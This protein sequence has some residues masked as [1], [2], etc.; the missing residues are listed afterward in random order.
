MRVELGEKVAIRSGT[1]ADHGFLERLGRTAF[2]EFDVRSGPH[3]LEMVRERGATTLVATAGGVA[4]G[5]VT[6]LLAETGVAHVLA[7]AVEPR[8]R[9]R[10][11]GQRLFAAAERTARSRGAH[12]IRLTTAQANVEAL[13][14]FLKLGLRIE[15]RMARFYG[16]GQDACELAKALEPPVP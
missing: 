15:R 4:I 10:G 3:M 12:A 8:H 7:I 11:V 14:L 2:G 9:G 5:F 1:E 6:L 16:R 13:S